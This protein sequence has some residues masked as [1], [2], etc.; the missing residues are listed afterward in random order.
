[1]YSPKG[2]AATSTTGKAG[3]RGVGGFSSEGVFPLT[4]Q[5]RKENWTQG[6]THRPWGAE[7]SSLKLNYDLI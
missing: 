5:F 4:S 6:S 2:Q 7:K 3:C 1:M